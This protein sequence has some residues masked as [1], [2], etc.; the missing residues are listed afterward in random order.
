MGVA[1]SNKSSNISN[2]IASSRI[3][4]LQHFLLF[5]VV[6][7]FMLIIVIAALH[8]IRRS[9]IVKNADKNHPQNFRPAFRSR[10]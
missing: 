2:S 6:V 3:L 4:L 8:A 1:G 10:S 5:A 9:F 7:V